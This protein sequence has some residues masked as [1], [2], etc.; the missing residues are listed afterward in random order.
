MHFHKEGGRGRQVGS[1]LV[2]TANAD[3]WEGVCVKALVPGGKP[4]SWE[5]HLSESTVGDLWRVLGR[6]KQGQQA[7]GA[8]QGMGQVYVPALGHTSDLQPH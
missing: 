5:G 3:S 7:G 8:S 4:S 1:G 2:P 6:R